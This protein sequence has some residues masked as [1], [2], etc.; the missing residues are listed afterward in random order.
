MGHCQYD[1]G[2]SFNLDIC[3]PTKAI[4][5]LKLEYC[6]LMPLSGDLCT[7]GYVLS[8]HVV[9]GSLLQ[10]AHFYEAYLHI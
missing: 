9:N 5:S 3:A 2:N 7:M 10:Y 6:L 4:S 8:G 1:T